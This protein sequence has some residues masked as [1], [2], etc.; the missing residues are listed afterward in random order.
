MNRFRSRLKILKTKL[1]KTCPK[2][3]KIVGLKP[4]DLQSPWLFPFIGF[5]ALVW[6]LIRVVPRPS[7]ARYPCQRVAIP[8]ATSFVLWLLGPLATGLTL[9]KLRQWIVKK[10]FA[11]VVLTFLILVLL[12]GGSY[13]RGVSNVIAAYTSHPANEPIGTAQGLAPGRVAWVHNPAVT[14][15]A[16]PD[17][18]QF[19]YD[20]I[21]QGVATDM[22]SWALRAYAE[23]ATDTAAWD[24]IFSHFNNGEGYQSGEKILIKINLVT[25]GASGGYA[26]AN[27]DPIY[28][29]GVTEDSTANSPQLLLALLDQLVNEAGVAQTDITIGDPTGFFVNFLY[30]PLHDVFP[31]VHYEDNRGTL[32]RSIAVLSNPC[33]EFSW[34]T[35]DAAG[36]TQ[37]CVVK[38]YYEADY[39]INFALLKSHERA[40]ITVAAK[41]H[42]GSMLRLPN[43]AGY[44]DLHQSLPMGGSNTDFHYMGN[45]R[46]LVDQMGSEEIGGK[47][48]LY[49]VDAIYGGKNW[50]STPSKWSLT[51][52]NGDWPSSLLMSMDPVAIDSV[53][54]DFLSQQWPDHVLQYEGVQDYLHEAAL[55]DDPPSGTFYDPEDDGIPMTSLGVHEHWNNP[56]DKQY[57][58]NL[59]TGDGIELLYVTSDPTVTEFDLTINVS[60]PGGGSTVPAVGTHAYE[61]G[62]VIEVTAASNPG[63]VFD[64]WSGDCEGSGACTVTMNSAKSVTAIFV[65]SGIL[66]DV[67]DDTVANSTD[68]L[69]IL[70]GDVGINISGYCPINC[71]DVNNDG[72]VNS[73]DA[74]ILLSADIGITVP[75]NVG[76]PGCP[77]SITQPPGCAN[78]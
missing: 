13:N 44:Y 61:S 29:S 30:T 36:K 70:S 14:D 77:T 3:G 37:D 19:W 40:G 62:T 25:V 33:V 69:I 11:N 41:N 18:S 68:A 66:G 21:N 28:K 71:G 75:F 4:V 67:N 38:S 42:Y 7:R 10:Q 24:D 54:F 2:S 35:A 12:V 51:P 72:I 53:A 27:Y 6:V 64:H 31:N 9:Y 8:L 1:F 59:G 47:T 43:S 52:F 20:H 76:Q 39:L 55:A 26:D 56:T 23:E 32:G 60:P 78:P 65:E 17:T 58:R 63:F 48:V 73:V 49:L 45:Y 5:A 15:W 74:L 50:S 16:G 57:S 34:S 22:M 46:T